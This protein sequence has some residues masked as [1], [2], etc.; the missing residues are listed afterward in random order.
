MNRKMGKM[1]VK[2]LSEEMVRS[3]DPGAEWRAGNI[4]VI[5]EESE[6]DCFVSL[7]W[8]LCLKACFKEGRSHRKGAPF[9]D[10]DL[11]WREQ[12][13]DWRTEERHFLGR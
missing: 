12:G 13:G 6:H 4:G 2:A 5:L 7:C 8:G 1:M 3:G 11:V 9:S 10:M